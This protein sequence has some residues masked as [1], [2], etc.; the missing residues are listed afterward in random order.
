MLDVS[1]QHISVHVSNGEGRVC[2]SLV[3][4]KCSPIERRALWQCLVEG[5]VD[6]MP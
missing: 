5:P 6:A 4:A 3:Y 1:S 2:C